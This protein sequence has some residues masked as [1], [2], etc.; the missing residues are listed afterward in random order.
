MANRKLKVGPHSQGAGWGLE[1]I[2]PLLLR[3]PSLQKALRPPP[4]YLVQFHNPRDVAHA[5][6]LH[7]KQGKQPAFSAFGSTL[8]RFRQDSFDLQIGRAK[9]LSRERC[10][11]KIAA[12]DGSHFLLTSS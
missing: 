2:L 4:D 11:N 5:Q 1:A 3:L 7:K 6:R 10:R 12:H 8:V 9:R